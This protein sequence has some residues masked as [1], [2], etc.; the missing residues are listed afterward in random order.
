LT[1]GVIG[2]IITVN[3]EFSG[4]PDAGRIRVDGKRCFI[5]WF[6]AESGLTLILCFAA[7]LVTLI[8]GNLITGDFH[9]SMKNQPVAHTETLWNI[10]GLF[11][12]GLGSVFLGG[13]P[14][15][16]LVLAGSGN[17]DSAITVVGMIVGG[18]LAH[19]LGTASSAAGT[20]ENGRIA[21]IVCIV[22]LLAIGFLNRKK[23][24]K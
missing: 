18:A 12:V 14:F 4:I 16:Q 22:I 24:A 8:V 11:V 2:C 6:S 19:N 3:R 20:T 13:C 9:L 23:V 17:A 7:L 15:R 5:D 1:K 10:L 21:V